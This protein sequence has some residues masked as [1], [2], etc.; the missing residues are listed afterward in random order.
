MIKTNPLTFPPYGANI[1]AHK[2]NPH[3]GYQNSGTIHWADAGHTIG[4]YLAVLAT[5]YRLYSTQNSDDQCIICLNNIVNVLRTIERLDYMAEIRYKK[6]KPELWQFPDTTIVPYPY[7]A[8]SLNGFFIRDDVTFPEKT[9]QEIRKAYDLS[10][11]IFKET[12]KFTADYGRGDEMSQDQVWNLLQGLALVKKLVKNDKKFCD[13]TGEMVTVEL[14]TQ[15]ITHR[16]IK[17]MQT[18]FIVHIAGIKC[19]LKLWSVINPVTNEIVKRGGK[20]ED[21]VFNAWFFARAANAIIDSTFESLHYG[22]D[23]KITLDLP[24]PGNKHF[25]DHAKLA[26]STISRTH[27]AA[28]FDT[29]LYWCYRCAQ[30]YNKKMP[31]SYRLFTYIHFPLMYLILH[32]PKLD[33]QNYFYH[34]YL[35]YIEKRLNEAPMHGPSS[36]FR[37]QKQSPEL[38]WSSG[39]NLVKPT[40]KDFKQRKVTQTNSPREYNGLDYMLLYNLFELVRQK[41]FNDTV[42]L[43]HN[44]PYRYTG[45]QKPNGKKLKKVRSEDIITGYQKNPFTLNIYGNVIIADALIESEAKLNFRPVKKL[46]TTANYRKN[47]HATTALKPY[48]SH[49]KQKKRQFIRAES[50]SGAPLF[51]FRI[52]SAKD[53]M[54]IQNN[55]GTLHW[56]IK[57]Y[58]LQSRLT[59]ETITQRK[60]VTL[61]FHKWRAHTPYLLQIKSKGKNFYQR[62]YI[63]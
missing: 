27:Y 14:W 1:P 22:Y 6:Q 12:P 57:V 52:D 11:P 45:W 43:I 17:S 58:D 21:L 60:T 46:I 15:K 62:I 44:L 59:F 32:E 2:R 36:G 50:S 5:E 33:T 48:E 13:G 42:K 38:F 24:M 47:K 34:Y 31:P 41:Y 54:T 3:E 28:S 19:Q 63:K 35:S 16:I 10:Q 8:G 37:N 18:R 23:P 29:L 9:K 53:I 49:Q 20:P 55:S 30:D 51:S 4:Y 61:S 39:K 7:P 56:A 25:N 26:L 40:G